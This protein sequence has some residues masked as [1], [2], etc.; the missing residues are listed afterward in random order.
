MGIA[1][2]VRDIT[3]ATLNDQLERAE[4][5]VK[6]IDQYLAAQK[7]QIMQSEQ[8]Y[9]QCVQHREAMRQQYLQAKL[10]A[11]KREEQAAIALKAG[12][13]EIARMALQDKLLHAEKR[14]QYK[15][16]YE[17]A[18]TSAM[19]LEQALT[20]LQSDY[21]EVVAKR[22]YYAARMESI[23]LRQQ[24]NERMA[25]SGSGG[26]GSAGRAFRRLEDRVSDMEMETR[27]LGELRRLTEETIYKA[28]SALKTGL[29]QELER[30]K[31]KIEKE[32]RE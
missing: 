27:A 10:M 4:D 13:D 12:E 17:Q 8:L 15:E 16:L 23:R 26:V 9:K 32:R 18:Y 29:E 28:G 30:L 14:D 19:E 25:H 22:Q 2:R 6:L 20:K 21:D 11:E 5:P 24:M 3:V 7:E 31:Q 1:R